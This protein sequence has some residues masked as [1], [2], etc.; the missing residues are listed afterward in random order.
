MNPIIGAS[1]LSF[2]VG[3]FTGTWK[4]F[5]GLHEGP[6]TA[7][8]RQLQGE[9]SQ[10]QLAAQKA[11]ADSRQAIADEK[12]ARIAER[13]T[14]IE[15]V[16]SSQGDVVMAG[17]ALKL[18]PLAAKTD[19]VRI[20]EAMIARTDFKLM[21]TIG[22]L[23]AEY[24]ASLVKSVA[25]ALA[26]QRATFDELNLK[27]D[28]DFKALAAEREKD[29]QL[30]D[31]TTARA[32]EAE[33]KAVTAQTTAAQVQDKLTVATDQVTTWA[34]KTR[35]AELKA[36][37]FFSAFASMRHWAYGI[38]AVAAFLFLLSC[39]FRHGQ[40][41]VGTAL[42][43]VKP[44]IGEDNYQKLVTTLDGRLDTFHQWIISGGRKSAAAKAAVNQQNQ[45]P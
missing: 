45:S 6:Q 4:P 18:M 26:G 23:P 41:S 3:I 39:Y 2:L 27:R 13:G 36:G 35:A 8:V 21:V 22:D 32:V 37:S 15:Q 9:L 38:G 29:R 1:L 10:A 30:I 31:Q 16:R 28:A 34:D 24:R 14:L 44:L 25:D 7:Q 40:R 5:A 11:S 20:A 42:Q 17:A 19:E 12:A 33:K 43:E